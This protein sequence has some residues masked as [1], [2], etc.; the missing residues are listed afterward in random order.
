MNSQTDW[1]VEV[2]IDDTRVTVFEGKVLVGLEAGG[3]PMEVVAGS[4]V[5]STGENLGSLQPLDL[6]SELAG[7]NVIPGVTSSPPTVRF[8]QR[9][10]TDW[11]FTLFHFATNSPINQQRDIPRPFHPMVDRDRSRPGFAAAGHPGPGA[12]CPQRAATA[13][14]SPCLLCAPDPR[15]GCHPLPGLR[16]S[17]PCRTAFLRKLR[18]GFSDDSCTPG[19]SSGSTLRGLSARLAVVRWCRGIGFAKG[20]VARSREVSYEYQSFLPSL[21]CSAGS[22]SPVL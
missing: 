21:R 22:R 10:T 1:A 12:D 7:W 8:P 2:G 9:Y 19:C 6:A 13:S 16:H 4:S 15:S 3:S 17:T 14:D 11:V 5:S 20:A 18:C